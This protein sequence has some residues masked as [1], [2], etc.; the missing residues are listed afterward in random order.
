MPTYAR[1]CQTCG[2]AFEAERPDATYDSNACRQRAY[3]ARRHVESQAA[4]GR[5]VDA[6]NRDLVA[7]GQP[8]RVRI[9]RFKVD[10]GDAGTQ[11]TDDAAH[12]VDAVRRALG[13]AEPTGSARS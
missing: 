13:L 12:G 4:I 10:G 2:R 1:T 7:A 5:R 11:E 8:Q 9:S 3:R 6:L